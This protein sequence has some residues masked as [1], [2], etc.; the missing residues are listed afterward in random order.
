MTSS[1]SFSELQ[2]AIRGQQPPLVIDVR[3]QPAFKAAT[4]MIAGALRREPDAVGAWAKELHRAWCGYRQ[5]ES[6][7]GIRRAA[8]DFP[9][10]VLELQ[11]RPR[12][13][14]TRHGSLRR[15]LRLVQRSG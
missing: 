5:A 13:A 11:E 10:P 6:C 2:S 12:N 1:V 4:D 15:A 9:R 14:C 7:V 8:R 3:K